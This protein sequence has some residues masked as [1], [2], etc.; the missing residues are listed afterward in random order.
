MIE[1][2]ITS[3]LTKTSRRA[4]RSYHTPSRH[5]M[6][7]RENDG[8]PRTA[9][10]Q[11]AASC[12][13]LSSTSTTRQT[14]STLRREGGEQSGIITVDMMMVMHPPNNNSNSMRTPGRPYFAATAQHLGGPGLPQ[15]YLKAPP[16]S[17]AQFGFPSYPAYQ[18]YVTMPDSSL[19]AR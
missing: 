9:L 2:T 12:D 13:H 1:I 16:P 7:Q 15:P 3:W 6:G 18:P 10:L 19:S 8:A 11:R 4:L 14:M 5:A 17:A